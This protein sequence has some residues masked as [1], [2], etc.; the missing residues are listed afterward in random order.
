MK[1]LVINWGELESAF[2]DLFPDA[3]RYLNTETGHVL[4][5]TSETRWELKQIYKKY[6]DPDNPDAF[7]IERV[8]SEIV[9]TDWEKEVLLAADLVKKHDENRTICIPKRSSRDGYSDMEAFI[10]TVQ[11]KRLRNQLQSKIQGRGMFRRF[12][13][14]LGQ[15]LA[16]QQRWYVFQKK[17]LQERMLEWLAEEGIEPLNVPEPAKVHQEA[18]LS[19]R[20]QLLN[21]VLIFVQAASQLPGIIR[22]ALIGSLTTDKAD[23]KDADLLVTVA[24]DVNLPA[25]ATLGRKLQGHCQAL[26]RGGEVFLADVEHHYL[27]RTCPWKQCQPGVRAACD[28]LNCGKR[29][30]LHDDL[31]AIKLSKTLIAKPP[32]ELW[33]QITAHVPVPEDV[34]EIVIRPL[35][36]N[37][38]V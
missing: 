16:E 18:L 31:S 35:Q 6:A 29:P 11:D 28:A 10:E 20:H 37:I 15:H 13:D 17:R 23:P 1:Q 24:N 25:L 4:L 30:F 14:I 5:V 34:T 22:I 2:A 33:P 19:L 7:V 8:L 12:R 21:G 38:N 26:N 27:G 3:N 9:N 36:Q 32:I